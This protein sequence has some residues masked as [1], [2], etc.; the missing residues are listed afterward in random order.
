MWTL[1][2]QTSKVSSGFSQKKLT[3]LRRR[4]LQAMRGRRFRN[5]ARAA[6][7]MNVVFLD[8]GPA[9]KLNLRYRRKNYATDVLS[10]MGEDGELGELVICP[11]VVRRQARE[12]GLTFEEEL[13]YMI[14][15]GWLHLLGYD[16]E[17]GRREERLMFSLQDRI[18]DNILK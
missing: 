12:H 14:L 6:G 2:D 15:H 18:F 10:F 13:S 5:K 7:P 8:A 4:I 9:R 17:L 1:I 16:H 3:E 11:S